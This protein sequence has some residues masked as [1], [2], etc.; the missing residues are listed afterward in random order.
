[1]TCSKERHWGTCCLILW[2]LHLLRHG[3]VPQTVYN[4]ALSIVYVS[5]YIVKL[6]LALR[7][8]CGTESCLSLQRAIRDIKDCRELPW[9]YMKAVK[10]LWW[11]HKWTYRFLPVYVINIYMLY[12]YGLSSSLAKQGFCVF[13]YSS[14]Y[15][16]EKIYIHWIKHPWLAKMICQFVLVDIFVDSNSPA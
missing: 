9:C 14:A 3:S 8:I 15:I 13:R 11:H 1:M 16:M 5:F 12:V 2:S 7:S 4:S 10:E 6:D